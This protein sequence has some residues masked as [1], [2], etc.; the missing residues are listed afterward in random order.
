M[1]LESACP[2][3]LEDNH[4][5]DAIVILGSKPRE[6][7]EVD[8]FLSD[9]LGLDSRR[10]EDHEKFFALLRMALCEPVKRW[11]S[12]RFLS[13]LEELGKIPYLK[14]QLPEAPSSADR[15]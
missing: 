13:D 7:E 10:D 4:A 6:P 12:V 5:E 2:G 15:G 11:D 9:E 1:L 14:L 8:K 3:L